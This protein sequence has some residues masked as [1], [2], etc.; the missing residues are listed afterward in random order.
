[1]CCLEYLLLLY[2]GIG[3]VSGRLPLTRSRGVE[4][5]FGHLLGAI[6]VFPVLFAWVGHIIVWADAEQRRIKPNDHPLFW[7]LPVLEL[8]LVVVCLISVY[9][10]GWPVS[11]D[12]NDPGP[13]H[14]RGSLF[15]PGVNL[16]LGIGL[17][18][19]GC[20]FFLGGAGG[21]STFFAMK[22]PRDNQAAKGSPAAR[23]PAL[24]RAWDDGNWLDLPPM[25]VGPGQKKDRPP[26]N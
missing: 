5:P 16:A 9:A 7:L 11:E 15:S 14:R 21:V 13:G 24:T 2:C 20:C 6:G 3:I 19:F 26:G 18:L 8:I 1:M 25:Q 23:K 17:C 4:P 22:V 12:A 10:I